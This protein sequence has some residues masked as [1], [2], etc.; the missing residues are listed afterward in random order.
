MNRRIKH[1]ILNKYSRSKLIVLNGYLYTRYNSK[2]LNRERKFKNF[3]IDGVI[4][5]SKNKHSGKQI[6]K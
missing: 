4:V 3:P 1:K 6:I 5:V 2:V